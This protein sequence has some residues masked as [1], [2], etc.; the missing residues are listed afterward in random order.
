MRLIALAVAALAMVFADAGA[1]A[2]DTKKAPPFFGSIAAGRARMRTGPGRTYP[3]NWLYQRADLPVRVIA[4]FKE[5]RKVEDP[6]GAQGWMLAALI[7]ERRTA[8][9]RGSQPIDMRERPS[10]GGRLMWR[11][12]PGVVGRLSQ[13]GGGWCRLD[14]K[15]QAAYVETRDLWGIDPGET[16]P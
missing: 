3:A 15:G 6:D 10:P 14:V 12:E 9:V 5:W 1:I 2:A 4:V 11:A 7:S 13:C 16:L 8:I